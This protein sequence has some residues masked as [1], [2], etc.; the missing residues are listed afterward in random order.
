MH[1][2]AS[3]V[4]LKLDIANPTA[5]VRVRAGTHSAAKQNLIELRTA[6]LVG[7]RQRLVPALGEF[8]G[9][10][11]SI[12]GGDEFRAPFL[13]ADGLDLV[14]DAEARQDWQVRGQE[15]LADMKARMALFL[16]QH[17]LI[18]ALHEKCCGGGARWATTDHEYVGLL[19]GNEFAPANSLLNSTVAACV[20]PM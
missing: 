12:P 14:G 1:E 20:G 7:E 4:G 11:T 15:R 13:H 19:Q 2:R 5:F 9:L 3:A 17:D 6:H 18:A 10:M 16:E 8:V